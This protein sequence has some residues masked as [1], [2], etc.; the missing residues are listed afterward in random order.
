MGGLYPGLVS[1]RPELL[2]R[3]SKRGVTYYID[4]LLAQRA[5]M[6]GAW[7]PSTKEIT[8]QSGA[9][10]LVAAHEVTHAALSTSSI[11]PARFLTDKRYRAARSAD[12]VI[13]GGLVGTA[14]ALFLAAASRKEPNPMGEVA[15]RVAAASYQS[16]VFAMGA[17]G[18]GVYPGLPV[19]YYDAN[20]LFGGSFDK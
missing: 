19:D 18:A 13:G 20:R 9:K 17:G 4:P 3:L 1:K 6:G 7:S 8:V 15:R 10:T 16:E 14:L 12:I 11:N 5:G 2:K